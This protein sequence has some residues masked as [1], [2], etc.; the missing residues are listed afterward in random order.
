[1][2]CRSTH[3]RKQRHGSGRLGNAGANLRTRSAL[4]V[5]RRCRLGLVQARRAWRFAEQD[6]RRVSFERARALA[7]ARRCAVSTNKHLCF[8]FTPLAIWRFLHAPCAGAVAFDCWALGKYSLGGR[9]AGST[10]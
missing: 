4:A 2:A 10:A 9:A 8:V 3:G 5:V 1:M 6:C 7:D